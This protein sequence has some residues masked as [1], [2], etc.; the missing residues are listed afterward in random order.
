M[1]PIGQITEGMSYLQMGKYNKRVADQNAL[2]A[3]RDASAEEAQVRQQVRQ[4]MGQQVVAAGGSGFEMGTGSMLDALNESQ[5]NGM[6]DQLTLRRRGE[7]SARGFEQQGQ[8]AKMQA[9]TQATAKFFGA[10]ESLTKIAKLDI[11]GGR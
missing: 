4:T 9:K 8:L 7:A 5:V 1:Q 3:R 6:I 11:P 10:A 2:E